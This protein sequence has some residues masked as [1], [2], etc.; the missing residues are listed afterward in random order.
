MEAFLQIGGER[1]LIK[2]KILFLAINIQNKILELLKLSRSNNKSEM[3][4]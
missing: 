3:V 1:Q 2:C 4:L